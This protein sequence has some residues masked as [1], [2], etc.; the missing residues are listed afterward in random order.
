MLQKRQLEKLYKKGLSANQI[1]IKT[2]YSESGVRYL[3]KR[4]SIPRRSISQAMYLK[5]NPNGDPFKIKKRL[6]ARDR[7]LMG[8]GLGLYWGEGTRADKNSVKLCNSDPMLIKAFR[9]F[10]TEICQAR[11]EKIYY[12]LLLFS[13]APKEEAVEFWSNK[14]EINPT[15]IST[16]TILQPR[17]KGTYRNKSTTGVLTIEFGNTKLKKELDPMIDRLKQ[18][19]I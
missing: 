5:A 9:M 18:S 1:A 13:D 12:R 2:N 16:I 4:Y 8:L 3:L 14:L 11:P 17:G 7:H 6:S 10:L 19:T 15:Q